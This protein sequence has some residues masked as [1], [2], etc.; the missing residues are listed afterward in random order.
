MPPPSLQCSMFQRSSLL[1][2]AQSRTG[3]V[4]QPAREHHLE[5][6]LKAVKFTSALFSSSSPSIIGS[7]S[8]D[9]QNPFPSIIW[10]LQVLLTKLFRWLRNLRPLTL[11]SICKCALNPNK[12]KRCLQCASHPLVNTAELC[13]SQNV[14]EWIKFAGTTS[15]LVQFAV[16]IDLKT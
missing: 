5:K 12:V 16:E 14:C 10:K 6:G 15:I 1:T 2:I 3:Q 4:A 9:P 13:L 8:S 11:F 7:T